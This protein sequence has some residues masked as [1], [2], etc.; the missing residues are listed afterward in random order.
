MTPVNAKM[1]KEIMEQNNE[2]MD[3]VMQIVFPLVPCPDT[4]S[5]YSVIE[6]FQCAD[7]KEFYIEINWTGQMYILPLDHTLTFQYVIDYI[8]GCIPEVVSF[9]NQGYKFE[10]E[11]D[12]AYNSE[13]YA[14]TE[15]IFRAPMTEIPLSQGTLHYVIPT[16]RT[17]DNHRWFTSR[18]GQIDSPE[19]EKRKEKEINDKLLITYN[20]IFGENIIS[21]AFAFAVLSHLNKHTHLLFTA[22]MFCIIIVTIG[23]KAKFLNEHDTEN[24]LEGEKKVYMSFTRSTVFCKNTHYI[25]SGTKTRLRSAFDKLR[26]EI[27]EIKN[28]SDFGSGDQD[29]LLDTPLDTF[30]DDLCHCESEIDKTSNY[31]CSQ[32]NLRA[33]ASENELEDY[34]KVIA[35]Q[36]YCNGFRN[37]IIYI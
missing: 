15:T 3:Q 31:D 12:V 27:D 23:I 5:S 26:Q 35:M 8:I 4:I 33:F 20:R 36:G 16:I 28:D 14:S 9:T 30:C 6:L 18:L 21:I 19:E 2:E 7:K 22:F 24:E 37:E 34:A 32:W 10:Y 29:D 17:L 11:L 13:V 1:Y 25:F